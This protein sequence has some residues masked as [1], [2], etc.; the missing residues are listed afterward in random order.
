MVVPTE[1]HGLLVEEA[2]PDRRQQHRGAHR[3]AATAAPAAAVADRR[4]HEVGHTCQPR[5]GAAASRAVG[6]AHRPKSIRSPTFGPHSSPSD[7]CGDPRV[8]VMLAT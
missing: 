3:N 2:E 8:A 5:S 1:Q 4:A 7:G 6:I